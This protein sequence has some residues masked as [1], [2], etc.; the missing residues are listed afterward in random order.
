MVLIM[1]FK[2]MLSYTRLFNPTLKIFAQ[3]IFNF[4]ILVLSCI[5]NAI[6]AGFFPIPVNVFIID[7]HFG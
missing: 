3:S 6:K 4:D 5:A 1:V 2:L 7:F